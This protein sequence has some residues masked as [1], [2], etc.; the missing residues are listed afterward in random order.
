M[1]VSCR[2][3]AAYI[4]FCPAFPYKFRLAAPWI[5]VPISW[6]WCAFFLCVAF[7]LGS[8]WNLFGFV[9]FW[10][11][12]CL[13]VGVCLCRIGSRR[14][15]PNL[16]CTRVRQV[17]GQRR[18]D[19][20]IGYRPSHVMLVSLCCLHDPFLGGSRKPGRRNNFSEL[21]LWVCCNSR[22]VAKI[23]VENPIVWGHPSLTSTLRLNQSH[24][25][26]LCGRVCRYWSPVT[27]KSSQWCPDSEYFWGITFWS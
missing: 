25:R 19:V 4:F 13:E 22:L 11:G 9:P 12:P 15:E 17:S 24:A 20:W 3:H 10:N 21:N 2:G 1:G 16:I 14:N 26:Y 8:S 18:R 23:L 7:D 27:E 6:G 5:S